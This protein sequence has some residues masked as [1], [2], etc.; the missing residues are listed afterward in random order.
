MEDISSSRI[1]SFSLSFFKLGF[2]SDSLSRHLLCWLVNLIKVNVSFRLR[3]LNY[4]C[5][6]QSFLQTFGKIE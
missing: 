2:L 1:A 6:F 5:A 3:K 4:G